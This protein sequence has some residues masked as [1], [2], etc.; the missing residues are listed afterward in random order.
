MSVRPGPAAVWTFLIA[1]LLSAVG[2]WVPSLVYL[3]APLLIGTLV[4]MFYD[5]RTLSDAYGSVSIRQSLPTTIGRGIPFEVQWDVARKWPRSLRAEFRGGVPQSA[6]PN[7]WAVSKKLGGQP[8]PDAEFVGSFK[9]PRRGKYE[10]GPI[11]LRLTGPLGLLDVKRTYQQKAS[12][13]V[14]PESYWS[15]QQIARD[16]TA[17]R[18][19]LDQ[20]ARSRQQGVGTEFESLAEFRTGDDSKRIDWRASARVNR[21]IVRRFQVERH[22]DV[23]LIID[24]GRLMATETDTGSK[25]DNAVDSA[26]MLSRVALQSGD[27]CGL[28][29][30]DDRVLGY[31]PPLSGPTAMRSLV[32]GVYDLQSRWRESD[33]SPMFARLKSRQQ[34]RSLIIIISDISGE[35]TTRR[36][37]ASLTSLARQHVVLFV[38]L[39]TP[40]LSALTKQP[41]ADML[42]ASRR[43][44]GFRLLRERE[45]AI[46][47]LK[48]SA[49][50]VLDVEPQELTVPLI[51][52]FV[53]LRSQNAL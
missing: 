5:W 48:R 13:D 52:Q 12:I 25:L 39:K 38:A 14:L 46:R 42:E 29:V 2:F 1:A 24:S 31:L 4:G 43:A 23:M 30:F 44:V 8:Q 33:F 17:E 40:Q 34:K 21:L 45:R 15:S 32:Q 9:L 28:G 11:W 18:Q 22:R 19:I 10:F 35:D 37:R 16:E 36:F 47:S 7:Q 49:V 6:K 27:R 41:V 20:V 26:L 53:E 50:H 51:N 3:V